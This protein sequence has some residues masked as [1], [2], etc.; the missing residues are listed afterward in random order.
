MD[1]FEE[2]GGCL[3]WVIAAVVILVIV[4]CVAIVFFGFVLD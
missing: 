2:A 4:A 1:L 3:V